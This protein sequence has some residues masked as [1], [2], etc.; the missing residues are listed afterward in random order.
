MALPRRVISNLLS[1]YN[2]SFTPIN[3]LKY[4]IRSYPTKDSNGPG[5]LVL[6]AL[7]KLIGNFLP[8]GTFGSG[9]LENKYCFN[10]SIPIGN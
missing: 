7:G 10:R 8:S 6:S 3:S 5:R 9:S 2:R 1:S 4:S